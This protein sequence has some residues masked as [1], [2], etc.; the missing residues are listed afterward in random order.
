MNFLHIWAIVLRQFYLIRSNYMRIIS[1]FLWITVDILLWGF[2]TRYLN[3]I[4]KEGIDFIK[5]LLGAVLFW[6]FF[7]RIMYGVTMGFLED[8]WARNFFNLFCSPITI[9]E[10][11][12]GLV[13]SSLIIGSFTFF[14]TSL[15]A[16]TMFKLSLF[17]YRV[18]FFYALFSLF[19]FGTALGILAISIMLRFGPSAEW[20]IWPL[21][22]I[23]SPFSGIFYPVSILPR[24]MK[25]VSKVLPPSY[26]FESLR[27]MI[28]SGTVDYLNLFW[29]LV[30]AFIYLVFFCLIFYLTYNHCL[31]IG[32]IARYS[33]ENIV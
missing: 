26:V 3:Y 23:I 2:L 8:V 4:N 1:I 14:I 12:W 19:V 20:V 15:I 25:I 7:N 17:V 18:I 27:G 6:I 30:I 5:L 28:L 24:W 21:P 10:Y 22:A 13:L 31:K 16:S 9:K 32:S 29:G 11:L 33:A